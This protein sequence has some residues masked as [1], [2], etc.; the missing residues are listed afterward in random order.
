MDRREFVV[1]SLA[2]LAMSPGSAALSSSASPTEVPNYWFD[3]PP[4]T[5]LFGVIVFTGDEP[6]EL[7][8]A[9]T[10]ERK[11]VRGRVM[12]QRLVE[13]TWPNHASQPER[14]ALRGR[15][16]TSGT[17]LAVED[18]A[19]FDNQHP[20]VG[21]GRRPLPEQ[22]DARVGAYPHHAVVFGFFER[23]QS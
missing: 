9:T 13:F 8:L 7:T 23:H 17:D 19:F 3:L 18:Y 21:L 4:H 2:A 14:I 10:R 16:L 22:V 15:S 5:S 6:V 1:R 20:I 12:G 11:V